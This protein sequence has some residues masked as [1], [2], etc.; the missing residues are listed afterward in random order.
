YFRL[1]EDPRVH[2]EHAGELRAVPGLLP[3]LGLRLLKQDPWETLASFIC[4]AAANVRK[5]TG[6]VEGIAQ[7]WGRPIEG[8]SR[9]AFPPAARLARATE[10]EL[11]ALGVGFRAPYLLATSR[12]IA[13]PDWSWSEVG[14]LGHAEARDRLTDLPGVGPKVAEC[15][16]LF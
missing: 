12:R 7:R 2:L 8:S 10:S 11:R 15:T 5:I 14:G 6:C 1:D 13:S 4:S 16:L 9:R 3:L